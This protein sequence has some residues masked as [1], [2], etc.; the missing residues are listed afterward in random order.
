MK[1]ITCE[2]FCICVCKAKYYLFVAPASYA[3]AR[4]WL[5]E[6]IR[7]HSDRPQVAIYN[8]PFVY[9]LLPGYTLSIKQLRHALH[10]VINKHQSLRTSL[11]FDA[12]KNILMQ[13]VFDS[14]DNCTNKFFIHIE[15]I[16]E[17]DEELYNI[18][19]DEQMEPSS[20]RSDSWSHFSMSRF[21][22]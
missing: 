16:F 7:F 2:R 10:L 20:F 17:T 21:V 15:S 12:G 22:L 9:R 18:M 19:E 8:M 13:G 4:I 3:Q 1:V 5:D 6:R 11:V 14:N